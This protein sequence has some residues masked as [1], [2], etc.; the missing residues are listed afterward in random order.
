MKTTFFQASKQVMFL[1]F[2]KNLLENFHI[3]LAGIF[4]INQNVIKVQN[5]ENIK[6]FY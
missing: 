1:K 3:I 4:Y 6:F 5:N 2:S